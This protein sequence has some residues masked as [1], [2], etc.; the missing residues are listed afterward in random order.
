MSRRPR[1]LLD[2]VRPDISI[3]VR[4]AQEHQKFHHDQHSRSR[5]FSVKQPVLVKN[6]GH[7]PKWLRGHITRC[8]GPLSYRV[9]LQDGR[10]VRR[11]VDHIQPHHKSSS[12]SNDQD[13]GD[14][15]DI[16]LPTS[17]PTPSSVPT[18]PPPTRTPT[19][20]TPAPS[21]VTHPSTPPR[22]SK[23]N[24]GPPKRYAPYVWGGK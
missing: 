12:D 5:Q 23:R 3:R 17:D 13:T 11:H 21:S 7:G 24:C 14:Y 22:R 8:L 15:L 18:T 4:R 10:S 20:T 2:M 9:F 6:F 1:S 19:S 16:P